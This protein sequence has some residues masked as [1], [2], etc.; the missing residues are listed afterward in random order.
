MKR[1]LSLVLG[2]SMAAAPVWADSLPLPEPTKLS[3]GE[4]G[5]VRGGAPSPMERG[6]TAAQGVEGQGQNGA[7][8]MGAIGASA[9]AIISNGIGGPLGGN[10]GLG[11]ILGGQVTVVRGSFGQ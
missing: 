5:A 7:P 10:G 2:I 11:S 6:K 1:V 9:G 4:L 3:A 8:A